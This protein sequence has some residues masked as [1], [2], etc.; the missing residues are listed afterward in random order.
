MLDS[1]TAVFAGLFTLLGALALVKA[2]S[3][4]TRYTKLNDLTDRKNT[5]DG[6]AETVIE[7]PVDVT[8]PAVPD[9]VPPEELDTE[10]PAALWA[11]RIRRKVNKSAGDRNQTKWETV[12]SGLTVGEFDVTDGW[13][14]VRVDTSSLTDEQTGLI[15]GEQDP[16]EAENLYLGDPREDIRLGDPD[17]ITKRLEDWGIIG[18]DGILGNI[19]FTIS[20]G[21]KTM[22]PDRYQATLVR[23]RDELLVRGEVDETGDGSVLRG[24]EEHPLV[25]ATGDL[26]DT[27]KKLHST[28]RKQAAVGVGLVLLGAGFVVS[29]LF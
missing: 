5:R 2:R 1:N 7:G 9:K 19:E 6:S 3:T 13:E 8:E 14:Q 15:R 16:F 18:D 25:I 21:W 4:H 20:L 24:T 23:E 26:E 10:T 27:G 28:A 17:P 11:W 12:E 22:S 29:G